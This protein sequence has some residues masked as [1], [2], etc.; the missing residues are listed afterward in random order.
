MKNQTV[1]PWLK[2]ERLKEPKAWF[3]KARGFAYTTRFLIDSF[4][5]TVSGD[6]IEKRA[7]IFGAIQSCPYTTGLAAE[8][9]MKGYLVYKGIDLKIIT[10]IDN[11]HNLMHLRK[12][13]LVYDSRFNNVHLKFVTD[14]LGEQ[15]MKNGGIRYPNIDHMPIY[16]NE[17]IDTIAILTRITKEVEFTIEKNK[18]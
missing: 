10:K 11:R 5:N 3:S 18:H 15:I 14:K 2:P 4:G 7:L 1:T 17:F 13:C 16:F 9:Y 6:S 12:M 8:L